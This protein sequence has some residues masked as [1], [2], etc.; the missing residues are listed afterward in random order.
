MLVQFYHNADGKT[1]DV[2]I[3]HKIVASEIAYIPNRLIDQR[4]ITLKTW[5]RENNIPTSRLD[6][7]HF[8]DMVMINYHLDYLDNPIHLLRRLQKRGRTLSFSL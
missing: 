4:A 8:E 6:F 3:N 5:C 2:L 7:E 1:V